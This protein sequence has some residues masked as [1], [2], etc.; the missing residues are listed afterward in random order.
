MDRDDEKGNLIQRKYYDKN[1]NVKKD[2]D[3]TDHGN[4]EEHPKVPYEHD[5]DWSK[6]NTKRTLEIES[7]R[8][9]YYELYV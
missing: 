8:L 4:P 2:I 6:I 7:G 3:F 9:I 1:G 5:W